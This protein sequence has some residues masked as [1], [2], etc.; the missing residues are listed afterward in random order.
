MPQIQT[1]LPHQS[2]TLIE[3]PKQGNHPQ[4]RAAIYINNRILPANSYQALHFP[5]SDVVMIK[6]LNTDE[7][8]H[9]ML[10]INIYNTKG[11]TLINYLSEFLQSYLRQHRYGKIAMVGDFNLHQPLWNPPKYQPH[12]H[13]AEDL[14][15]L[16][17][18]NGLNLI[19]PP[20][21]ITLPQHGTTIDL[22]WGN[23]Q[24][25]S[26]VLKCKI[27]RN[28]DHGSDHLPI[29]TMFMTHPVL[30]LQTPTYNFEKTDWDLL[31][32]K[33]KTISL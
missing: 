2:W 12:D 7:G 11:T 28:H 23:A 22:T 8:C 6:I 17:A 30:S 14:I 33:L 31:K 18:T 16:M 19:L 29:I 13:E 25:E 26:N 10:L 24:M 3:P 9:P 5:S 15:D 21:T 4:P 20:G 27:A 32:A 1:S